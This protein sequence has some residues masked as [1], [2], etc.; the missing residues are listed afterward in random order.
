[1][2]SLV[3]SKF[4]AM[5]NISL[6]SV[7]DIKTR[8]F[9]G[10]LAIVLMLLTPDMVEAGFIIVYI[11]SPED[12]LE[13]CGLGMIGVL[14]PG[15]GPPG[16]PPYPPG[17]MPGAEDGGQ[18]GRPPGPIGGMGPGGGGPLM[19]PYMGPGPIGPGPLGGVI[20]GPPIQGPPGPPG[21]PPGIIGPP[22]CPWGGIPFTLYPE[23]TKP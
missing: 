15:G 6:Y 14:A 22:G 12:V 13:S 20:R 4:L 23:L 2:F 10:K 11:L 7:I 16:G 8:L 18:G 3:S 9:H 17:D 21:G 19:G 5:R 1:M